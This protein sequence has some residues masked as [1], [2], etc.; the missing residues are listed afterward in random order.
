MDGKN[1]L[2]GYIQEQ[3]AKLNPRTP[4]DVQVYALNVIYA[5]LESRGNPRKE[6]SNTINE[7]IKE[8]IRKVKI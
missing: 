4:G 3:L 1:K 8:N 6:I 2:R 5:V 7:V